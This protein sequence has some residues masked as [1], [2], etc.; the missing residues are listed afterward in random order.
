MCVLWGV[1]GQ[2]VHTYA[3]NRLEVQQENCS[4]EFS[5]FGRSLLDDAWYGVC[6][7]SGDH[8]AV[9]SR[10]FEVALCLL[11]SCVGSIFLPSLSLI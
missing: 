10:L 3:V 4:C 9:G 6:V 5:V 1:K 7:S 8:S 11:Y 2:C